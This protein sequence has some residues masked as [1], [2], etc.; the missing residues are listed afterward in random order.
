MILTCENLSLAYD[1]KQVFT[2]I[3]LTLLP[4]SITLVS[5]KNGS[6]KT[7]FLRMIAGVLPL[8]KDS[9]IFINEQKI[10]EVQKPYLN[11]I[12][13]QTA[14]LEQLTVLENLEFWA[15]AYD[16]ELL[17][18]SAITYFN[19]SEFIDK[20]CS[21]LSAGN[22]KK[23]ALARLV[24]CKSDLWLL[25]EVEVNLDEENKNLLYNLIKVKADNGGIII[26]SSH[27][28]SPFKDVIQ[29]QF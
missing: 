28:P 19:L 2:D 18:A 8:Q 4:G 25:D 24:C 7:S 15:K 22:R 5:G 21:E 16:S 11:F 13:H 1:E 26:M 29:I 23:V 3:A 27:Y 9:E 20:K 14:V 6:G 17:I 10:S 12:E